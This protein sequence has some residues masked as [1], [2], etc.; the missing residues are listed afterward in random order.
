MMMKVRAICSLE[1]IPTSRVR[2][3]LLRISQS[4]K[5]MQQEV[6]AICSISI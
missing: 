3:Q 5:I 4:K 1:L 2:E 6:M